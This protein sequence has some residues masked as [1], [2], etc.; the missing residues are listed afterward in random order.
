[1]FDVIAASLEGQRLRSCDEAMQSVFLLPWPLSQLEELLPP[2]RR[3][4]QPRPDSPHTPAMM[5]ADAAMRRCCWLEGA[6]AVA[7]AALQRSLSVSLS[8]WSLSLPLLVCSWQAGQHVLGNALCRCTML[9]RDAP[10][11]DALLLDVLLR[12]ARCAMCCRAMRC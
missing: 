2:K 3:V 9:M 8:L 10:L 7:D 5:I 1:L 6:D 4:L 11:H 12:D